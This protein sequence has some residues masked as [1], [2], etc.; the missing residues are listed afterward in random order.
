MSCHVCGGTA[1]TLIH[2]DYASMTGRKKYPS[3]GSPNY[4][5]RYGFEAHEACLSSAQKERAGLM[6]EK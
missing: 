6:K 3:L 1:G 5:Q 4:D 2:L